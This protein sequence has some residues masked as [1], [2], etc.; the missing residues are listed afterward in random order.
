MTD[1]P[2]VEAPTFLSARISELQTCKVDSM[3][4]SFGGFHEV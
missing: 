4:P 3:W 2:T 1:L